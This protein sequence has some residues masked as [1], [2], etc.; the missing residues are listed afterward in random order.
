MA[1]RTPANVSRRTSA[2][3]CSRERS[4]TP[5][6]HSASW[7]PGQQALLVHP[8]ILHGEAPA[9][10]V[11]HVGRGGPPDRRLPVDDHRPRVAGL[12]EQVVEAEVPV[13]GGAR[14]GA[15]SDVRRHVLGEDVAHLPVLGRHGILVALE[16]AR[17]ERRHHRGQEPLALGAVAVEPF[18]AGQFG[19]LPARRVQAGHLLQHGRR[20]VGGAPADLVSLHSAH[21][22]LEEQGEPPG[23]RFHL[24]HVGGRHPGLDAGGHLAVEADLNFVGTQRQ[25]GSPA[26]I[27]GRGELADHGGR[28]G[29]RTVVGEGETCGIAHLARPD[30]GALE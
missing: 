11:G 30:G 15:Q 18:Q 14:A 6:R 29:T 19:R 16:E 1:M 2:R 24:G 3:S 5:R 23:V 12:E 10:E 8:P 9:D 22:V 17:R 7:Y 13:D 20:R 26:L 25:T 28:A 27:V 4:R 21:H